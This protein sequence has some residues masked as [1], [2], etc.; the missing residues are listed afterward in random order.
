M[1]WKVVLGIAIA[2]GIVATLILA[3]GSIVKNI[4]TN[5]LDDGNGNGSYDP[6][7]PH[8]PSSDIWDSTTLPTGDPPG[9]HPPSSDAW[10]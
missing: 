7:G 4:T 3:H 6:P 5:L 1:N 8:P 2:V 9:P 10:Q